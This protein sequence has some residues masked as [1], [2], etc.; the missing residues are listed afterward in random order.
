MPSPV[1]VGRWTNLSMDFVLGLP[2]T[3]RGN[4]SIFVVVDQFS[5]LAHFIAC[6]KTNGAT[7]I[8]KFFFSEVVHL[9]GLPKIITS[10]CDTKFLSHFWR[11]LWKKLGT[12][13]QFNSA[14]HPQTNGKNKVVNQSLENL[15]RCIVGEKP[16]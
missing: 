9:H 8:A 4:D 7:R 16:K 12:K 10:G 6:K 14:Y 5:K 11:T 2:H 1:L 13:L 15:L 3:Q